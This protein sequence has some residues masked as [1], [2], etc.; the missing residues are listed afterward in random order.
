MDCGS[1]AVA[2]IGIANRFVKSTA[3]TAALGR[4]PLAG[5]DAGIRDGN[6]NTHLTSAGGKLFALVEG[7][8]LPVELDEEL[9]SVTRSDFGGSL[10]AGFT[11][12]PKFDPRT[13]LRHAIT[14]EVV[15]PVRYVRSTCRAAPPPWRGSIC[16]ICR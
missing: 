11:A 7:G 12:H 10:E 5:P 2:L 1:A 4:E 6:V 3:A 9:E 14:Y 15:Q 13:G 16:P 8:D